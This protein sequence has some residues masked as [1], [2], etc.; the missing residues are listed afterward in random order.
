M[1]YI[2]QW[3]ISTYPLPTPPFILWKASKRR[4]YAK[5]LSCVLTLAS[6]SASSQVKL[7]SVLLQ[8]WSIN[9][10]SF[11]LQANILCDGQWL[12]LYLYIFKIWNIDLFFPSVFP[13]KLILCDGQCVFK[14]F[15]DL[16][17]QSVFSVFPGKQI[18][19]HNLSFI[20]MSLFFFILWY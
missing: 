14:Y 4:K 2:I 9:L 17:H 20:R 19:C 16:K 7:P 10:F 3:I 12:H 13:W 1:L 15:Q 18:L 11:P 6:S 8:T 5:G